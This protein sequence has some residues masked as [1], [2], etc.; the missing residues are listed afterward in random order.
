M[1]DITELIDFNSPSDKVIS[2]LKSSASSLPSSV[3]WD[4]MKK[5]Y[6]P[7]LHFITKDTDGRKDKVRSDGVT[8]KASRI[9]FGLEK[10]LVSRMSEFMFAIPVKRV[11]TGLDDEEYADTRSQIIR[12]V[13]MIY[14]HARINTENLKRATSV[15]ASSE[16]LTMWYT[17]KKQN[18][19]YGFPCSHKLKCKTYSAMDGYTIY[20]LFDEYDDLLAVSIEYDKVINYNT[21]RYFETYTANKHYKWSQGDK[22]IT[23]EISNWVL[24]IDEDI[25]LLKIPAIYF[26]RNCPIYYGLSVLREEIEYAL[27]RNS[28]TIAYNASPI[29]KVVGQL[30]D[31][32]EDKGSGR[33]VWGV[34]NGGDISYV[35]WSQSIEATKYHVE[36]LLKLFFMQAQMPDVSF[37]NMKGLGSI[38]YDARQT[39]LTDAHL[40]VGD[41]SGMFIECLEREYNIVKAF[42]KLMNPSWAD[43][44][45]EL[46]VEHII[47]PFVQND[48][49]ADIQK[50][51][52]ACGNKAV[53]SQEEAIAML[54]LS[55]NPKE[56]L[57]K[58]REDEQSSA[59]AQ[60]A[61]LNQL[62]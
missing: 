9:T 34:E 40:K 3:S 41:E 20:P 14:K 56:T 2:T 47:T 50:W 11:Y 6:E 15:F 4:L 53:V 61:Q 29:L 60:Q 55:S 43:L 36:Q 16:A 24:L 27:S 19:I 59:Q 38:G 57:D 33:R 7:T 25:E 21:V 48:E 54:G 23:S 52:L 44:L 35:S 32:D 42:L 28:D 39:I 17:E 5:L 49:K 22:S 62:F 31:S 18:S 45:D 8:D 30:T 51:S 12:A 58:I 1:R 37:E 26:H 13:E 46:D 10:L